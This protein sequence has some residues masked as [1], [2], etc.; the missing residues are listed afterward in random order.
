MPKLRGLRF[1]EMQAD[2]GDMTYK[3]TRI[4][5]CHSPYQETWRPAINAYRCERGFRICVD[6]AG[7]QKGSIDLQVERPRLTIRGE[8]ALPEP[9]HPEHPVQILAMEIDHGPFA[10]VIDLPVA[11]DA[12]HTTAEQNNG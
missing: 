6:L 4:S 12:Q 2:L 5:F 7:I 9:G 3:L 8:R 1:T 10:R 11:V